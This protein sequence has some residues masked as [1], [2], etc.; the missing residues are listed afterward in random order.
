MAFWY[1][2]LVESGLLL[3]PPAVMFCYGLLV[4]PSGVVAFCYGLLVERGLLGETPQY[5][6]QVGTPP[7]P[8]QTATVVDSTHPTGMHS[9]LPLAMRYLIDF[10]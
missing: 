6:G 7:L 10:K 3:W 4:R 1:G 2:L 9:C 5:N 8:L